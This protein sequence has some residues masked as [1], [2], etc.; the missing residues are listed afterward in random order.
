MLGFWDAQDH[1]LGPH[2]TRVLPARHP[3]RLAHPRFILNKR[4][5]RR[6]A[7][8]QQTHALWHTYR[9]TVRHR[10]IRKAKNRAK[11]SSGSH[12][13]AS[14]VTAMHDNKHSPTQQCGPGTA[15]PES[16]RPSQPTT[17][18]VQTQISGPT[19]LQLQVVLERGEGELSLRTS[20]GANHAQCGQQSKLGANPG[21]DS[22][23]AAPLVIM[24][25][26]QR[27]LYGHDRHAVVLGPH[28]EEE[29]VPAVLS[30]LRTRV[31]WV[32]SGK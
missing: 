14:E 4:S 27:R 16:T 28:L 12:A 19:P 25:S 26:R 32:E 17:G 10:R 31:E 15:A 3:H 1:V 2:W 7:F 8:Q 13:V 23:G 21:R 18:P 6:R 20:N 24:T 9:C 11:R 30:L 22:N 29:A 5:R